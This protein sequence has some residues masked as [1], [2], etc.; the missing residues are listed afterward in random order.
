MIDFPLISK[1]AKITLVDGTE[2][3]NARIL[4]VGEGLL[5]YQDAKDGL[6]W[7]PLVRIK[8]IKERGISQ[9]AQQVPDRRRK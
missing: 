1:S 3:I 6:V 8:E 7:I 4:H 2:V 5:Q 9:S